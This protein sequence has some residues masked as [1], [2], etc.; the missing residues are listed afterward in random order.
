MDDY[1]GRTLAESI[2]DETEEA[3]LTRMDRQ[4]KN[5]LSLDQVAAWIL[6]HIIPE[7]EDLDRE[8]IMREHLLP[9]EES[10][11][12]REDGDATVFFDKWRKVRLKSGETA[13]CFFFVDFEPQN[14][15]YP[16]YPLPKRGTYYSCRMV[17]S[18]IKPNAGKSPYGK[19]SKVYSIWICFDPP[20]GAENSA[21]RIG[22]TQSGMTGNYAFARE[23]YDL[24]EQWYF[25][26]SDRE[27]T[28]HKLLRFFDV[29]FSK[30]YTFEER[31]KKLEALGFQMED[32]TMAGQVREITAEE[33]RYYDSRFRKG[34]EGGKAEGY[35]EGEADGVRKGWEGGKAEGRMMMLAAKPKGIKKFGGWRCPI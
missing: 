18:Q 29:L 23:D 10:S 14:R 28:D 8:T 35:K 20:S 34:W 30:E 19:I 32:E 1:D 26:L 17:S 25:L 11:A 33:L 16:G 9:V 15:F 4:A 27:E 31:R 12:A 5:L 13:Q 21:I 7:F 2:R 3:M 22:M 6:K 24:I